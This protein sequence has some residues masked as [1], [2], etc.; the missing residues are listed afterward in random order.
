MSFHL[1]VWRASVDQAAL[2]AIA[3]INDQAIRVSGNDVTVP[4]G[5]DWLIGAYGLGVNLT[6]AQLVSPSLRRFWNYEIE[7]IDVGA[8][9]ASPYP[10]ALFPD[11][12]IKLMADENLNAFTSEGGAGATLMEVGAFLAT[13]AV[14]PVSGDIRTIRATGATTLV[15]G[16]WTQVSLTFGETLPAGRYQVVGARFE[17]AGC[18]FGRLIFKG[19]ANQASNILLRPGA[20]GRDAISDLENEF[21]RR[22]NLGVWGE[23]DH[24][25]PPDAEFC[26][27]AADTAQVVMLDLIK[28]L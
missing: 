9:P 17:S 13:G 19:N 21:F 15:A 22:G 16:V 18:E 2:A 14:R 5:V 23:F 4:D 10:I 8:E 27:N 25:T 26:S 28:I 7:P 11:S 1:A 6:R 3:A 24:N 20:V 12:P